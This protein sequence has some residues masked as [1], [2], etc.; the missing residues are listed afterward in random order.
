MAEL[1]LSLKIS[2]DRAAHPPP[3]SQ[4]EDSLFH[5]VLEMGRTT[6]LKYEPPKRHRISGTLLDDHLSSYKKNG[7]EG[8]LYC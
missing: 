2:H 3:S 7:I 1:D 8:K 5:R 6:N 4:S